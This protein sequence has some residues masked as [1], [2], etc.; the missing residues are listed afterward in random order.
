MPSLPL[1]RH[2]L[3]GRWLLAAL[4]LL[5]VALGV[6]Y[7]VKASVGAFDRW[8][9]GIQQM[10]EQDISR[11]F[12]YPN[13][14]IMAVILEPLALLP[15]GVGAMVWFALKA[16]MALVSLYWVFRLVEDSDAPFP[17]WAA[18]L[19][20][21]LS[22]KPIVDDL[23]HGNVNLFILFL[24][25]ACLTAFRSR[26]DLLAGLLLALAISCKV[27]PALFVPYFVWK[28][29]WRL[30]IGC[31]LGMVLFFYPGLVPTLRL[32]WEHNQQQLF[33][34]YEGMVKPFV[35]DGKV[36]SEH[37]NQSLPGLVFRLLTDSP[38]FVTWVDGV[39]T[40]ARYHN[41]LSLSLGQAKWL[42]KG[43]MGLFVLLF[44]FFARTPAESRRGWRLAAEMGLV[45]LGMLLFS[46]RT[47]KHHCVTLM[48]PLGV[49]CYS[50]AFTKVRSWA[51][52][53]L[54]A[55]LG[56]TVGLTLVTGV[57]SGGKDRATVAA[58][59][60]VAKLALV[61]GAY[62]WACLVLLAAMVGLLIRG[63][64]SSLASGVS[65]TEPAVRAA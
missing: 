53:G 65:S 38:S 49:V 18:A 42:V 1:V 22:L 35:I 29:Q 25:M 41:V 47:W 31:A 55:S 50:L 59:P 57:V 64:A 23:N 27:T 30:L 7:G 46:E 9:P 24:V 62:T 20:V 5:F 44:V 51:C 3:A 26:R 39:E 13:P 14:P 10:D 54:V 6:R 52:W 58:S 4:V 43:C 34:W 56:L 48:L 61:Y 40:P 16:A 63:R 36:T 19:T 12:N 28:R 17:P 45:M 11:K 21:L 15:P 60:G 2:P 8:R 33:S 37:I 32:G